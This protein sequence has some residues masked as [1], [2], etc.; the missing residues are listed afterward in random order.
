MMAVLAV[1]MVIVSSFS[2]DEFSVARH[3]SLLLNAAL[4]G[5]QFGQPFHF[6]VW[7]PSKH[8]ASPVVIDHGEPFS[9]VL[10]KNDSESSKI[11]VSNAISVPE[12]N[13][14][15]FIV[16]DQFKGDA[17][18][19][20]FRLPEEY[21]CEFTDQTG[22]VDQTRLSMFATGEALYRST[23]IWRC[24]MPPEYEDEPNHVRMVGPRKSVV[25]DDVFPIAKPR[26][27]VAKVTACLQPIKN[28][29]RGERL[30]KR[31]LEYTNYYTGLGV[32]HFIAYVDRDSEDSKVLLELD[33]PNVTIVRMSK[34]L[35]P[36][37]YGNGPYYQI[38]S[39]ANNDCIWRT[40]HRSSWTM[41]QFDVDEYIIGTPSLAHSLDNVS[42][43]AS[44]V[45]TLQHLVRPPYDDTLLQGSVEYTEKSM[46]TWGKTIVRPEKINVMWVHSATSY[47]GQKVS[48]PSLELLHFRALHS[49]RYNTS[50]AMSSSWKTHHW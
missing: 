19:R 34:N 22:S 24:D 27:P 12:E 36:M 40:R 45:Y 23:S 11:V 29:R 43:D 7:A 46:P 35:H 44:Q 41:I 32:E 39:F 20:M 4:F 18:E 1:Y 50:D 42:L 25:G 47:S 8:A 17:P 5:R 33:I 9:F 3:Q 48:L 16:Y 26:S 31:L 49:K 37:A 38:Q 2:V 6:G 10:P 28:L 15:V 21:A 14:V 13:S 30:H